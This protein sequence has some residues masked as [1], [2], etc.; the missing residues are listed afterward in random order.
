MRALLQLHLDLLHHGAVLVQV[1]ILPKEIEV[2]AHRRPDEEKIL[3]LLLPRRADASLDFITEV[4]VVANLSPRPCEIPKNQKSEKRL[5]KWRALS[6]DRSALR[7]D[8]TYQKVGAPGFEPGTSTSSG[9]IPKSPNFT[10]FRVKICRKFNVTLN[11]V[12]KRILPNPQG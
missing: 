5:K 3:A 9:I 11:A 7:N 10:L 1:P 8:K 6:N 12:A 4:I 2:A